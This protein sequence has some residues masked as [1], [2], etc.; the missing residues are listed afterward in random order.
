MNRLKFILAVGLFLSF[1]LGAAHSQS[2]G[3]PS[4]GTPVPRLTASSN[5][6]LV[7]ALVKTKA[8]KAV[9]SLTADDFTLTDDG[10]PQTLRVAQDI[11][12]QPLAMVIVVQTGGQGAFYLPHYRDLGAVLDAVIGGGPH[13][14]AVVAFDSTARLDQDF[15]P[16]TDLAASNIAGLHEGDQGAAIL[17]AL[18][19]SIDLLRRQPPAYRRAVLLLSETVDRGSQ[20]SLE[21]AV[22]AVDDSNTSI[23]SVSFST[24]QAAVKHEASKIPLPEGTA[25]SGKPYAPGGC[26][27]RDPKADPDAHGNRG[28]QALDCAGDL[29]PPLRI[30]RI[31]FIAAKD[32]LR[33]NVPKTV[34][35]L[36]GGEYFA[37]KDARSLAKDLITISNHV[38]NY[39]VV[40]FRPQSPHSGFHA[41]ELKVKEKRD[42]EVEA[43]RGY[44]VNADPAQ[45]K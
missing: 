27:S 24:T 1:S 19:F 20:T 5:L 44:W 6:V 31:A 3:Q 32:G 41:L 37:F 8:G 9:F 39:Y 40:S 12:A 30:A 21:D 13:Q 42:Y 35:Q 28:I 45:T 7:P 23:Y 15:N 10:V 11:D 36:T 22:R 25:Y 34:A 33:R 18:K 4:P 29:L 14:V 38:P 2:T 16:D 43:R 26:M 17:D